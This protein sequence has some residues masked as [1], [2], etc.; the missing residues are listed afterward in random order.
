[1]FE[2][3]YVFSFQLNEKSKKR[4]KMFLFENP[5]NRFPKP[6]SPNR[7]STRPEP[8]PIGSVFLAFKSV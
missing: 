7:F 5:K 6:V 1:M 4:K 3:Y 8:V 2:D